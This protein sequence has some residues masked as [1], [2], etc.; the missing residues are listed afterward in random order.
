MAATGLSSCVKPAGPAKA[1]VTDHTD[2]CDA[3]SVANPG[4]LAAQTLNN[5]SPWQT[6]EDMCASYLWN[7]EPS[8]IPVFEYAATPCASAWTTCANNSSGNPVNCASNGC[9]AVCPG[10]NGTT[11]CVDYGGPGLLTCA[12]ALNEDDYACTR[13]G[14][15]CTATFI[16]HEGGI[17]ACY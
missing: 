2:C 3:D 10:T 1:Y 7:C 9:S 13:S 8:G 14:T 6:M 12:Q 5:A 15:L 17:Q 16:G 11:T 4:Y